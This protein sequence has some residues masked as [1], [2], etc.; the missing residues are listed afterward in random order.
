M[1]ELI[2]DSVLLGLSVAFVYFALHL[3]ARR[4]GAPAW[5]MALMRRRIAVLLTIALVGTGMKVRETVLQ[6]SRFG[7][8]F[9][10]SFAQSP[11]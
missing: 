9:V 3:Y 2:A 4:P 7:V 10:I 1:L 11:P 8:S 6:Q 5:T